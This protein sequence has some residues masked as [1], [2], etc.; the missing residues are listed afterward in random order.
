DVA[1]WA[2]V[3]G[4]WQRCQI[5]AVNYASQ[6][7]T[8]VEP[9]GVTGTQDIEVYYTHADGQFRFRVARDAG[10]VDDSVATVFNQSFSTMHSV[11]QNNL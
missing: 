4:V 3:G 8:F 5:N 11:D 9:A 7:V 1:V 2:K 6:Q 10:G